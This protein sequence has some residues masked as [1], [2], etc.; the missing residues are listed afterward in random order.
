MHSPQDA[1]RIHAVRDILGAF[2]ADREIDV[3]LT[4]RHTRA[5]RQGLL[6][7]GTIWIARQDADEPDRLRG[8]VA[9]EYAH[10]V[11]D[12]ERRDRAVISGAVTFLTLVVIAMLMLSRPGA[13]AASG[14]AP[15]VASPTAQASSRNSGPPEPRIA[16]LRSTGTADQ[17]SCSGAP[18]VLG[19]DR[20][21]DHQHHSDHLDHSCRQPRLNRANGQVPPALLVGVLDEHQVGGH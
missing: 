3:R 16:T 8:L 7:A 5:R 14:G 17:A 19:E 15:G 10:L 18:A 12:H 9:H 2:G 11:D 6:G 13:I 4:T 21:G 1:D 20:S